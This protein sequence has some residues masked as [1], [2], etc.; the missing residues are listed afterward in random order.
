MACPHGNR[1]MHNTLYAAM[2]PGYPLLLR[3]KAN[4]QNP[5]RGSRS[6]PS[7]KVQPATFCSNCFAGYCCCTIACWP[8]Q[9]GKA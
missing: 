4:A 3:H 5:Q 2:G 7:R 8:L 9:N 1:T 6:Y